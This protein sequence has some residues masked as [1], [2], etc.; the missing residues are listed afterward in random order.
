[1]SGGSTPGASLWV[2]VAV[3][4]VLFAGAPAED[5]PGDG[6]TVRAVSRRL[7]EAGELAVAPELAERAGER[8][9]YFVQN[10][11]T[12]RWYSKY[13][14]LNAL[15]Y[16]PM[17]A[18]E[19]AVALRTGDPAARQRAHWWA[20]NLTHVLLGVLVAVFLQRLCVC[21]GGTAASSALTVLSTCFAS[22]AWNYLR[23]QTSESLQA[24]CFLG[25][26]VLLL[27][28][29]RTRAARWPVWGAHAAFLLLC[30]AKVSHLVLLPLH[31][32]ALWWVHRDLRL[33]L[34][35]TLGILGVLGWMNHV[36]F[37]SALESGYAQWK[38]EE[39]LTAGSPLAA[40]T[41]FL[42]HPQRSI[43]THFPVLVP[44]IAGLVLAW[45][46]NAL[47]AALA[48]GAFVAELAVASVFPNWMGAWSYGPRYLLLPLLLVAPW[49]APAWQRLASVRTWARVPMTGAVAAVLCW[50]SWQQMLVNALPFFTYYQVEGTVGT[51]NHEPLLQRVR[52]TPFPTINADLLTWGPDERM[53]AFMV[54]NAPPESPALE[55]AL[56][57]LRSLTVT[58]LA[59]WPTD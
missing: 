32:G 15:L 42:F 43:F 34:V 3:A 24:V 18:V 52:Q 59:W 6:V 14:P 22:F 17:A 23:A 13:G 5:Y 28:S 47:A 26:A 41:G 27:E 30:T 8:G 20:I 44:S 51:L 1:M 9:Q 21:V 16:V 38:R 29:D 40:V 11:E 56:R 37:G 49:A 48:G 39:D 55:P 10:P 12:G 45:R 31:L 19:R 53:P 57:H 33:L 50:A 58:N 4:L 46:K 25:W 36:R 7:V 2:P 54:E 35:P